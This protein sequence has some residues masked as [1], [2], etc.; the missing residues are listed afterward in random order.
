ML[1]DERRGAPAVM[2]AV[3][4]APPLESGTR[5]DPDAE[6]VGRLA[7][8]DEAAL[9][10]FYD[11]FGALAFG[12]ALRICHDEALA[13]DVVQDSFVAAWT[14]AGRFDPSRATVKTW[15]LAIVHHRAID[16]IRRARSSE[17]LPEPDAAATPAALVSPDVWGD[18]TARL[19]ADA[20]R[21]AVA[22]LPDAQ[23]QVLL[24]A[25]FG[26]L[27]Q[28]EI[29]VKTGAPLGTVKGRIRLGLQ[30]LRRQLTPIRE[31]SGGA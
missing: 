3:A 11:R 7:A 5:D 22:G 17:S 2:A 21:R 4:N 9:G 25:Y 30:T 31:R 27:T 23:R 15:F 29:A 8:G 28:E 16:V 20:L 13:Q 18:V 14:N 19:D 10:S 6:V 12:V 26:G 1:N 24:L